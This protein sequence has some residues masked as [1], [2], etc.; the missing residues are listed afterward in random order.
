M[1]TPLPPLLR[2]AVMEVQA[3]VEATA[4]LVACST[5]NRVTSQPLSTLCRTQP[6]WRPD[7]RSGYR[8]NPI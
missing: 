6:T 5:I 3:F 2:E 4:A 8:A 7:T 1:V